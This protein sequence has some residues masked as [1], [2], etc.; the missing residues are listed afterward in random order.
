MK[1]LDNKKFDIFSQA[2]KTIAL[3]EK[4]KGEVIKE[5]KDNNSEFIRPQITQSHRASKLRTVLNYLILALVAYLL[6]QGLSYWLQK[7]T[8]D[9]AQKETKF[10]A[11]EVK[12]VDSDKKSTTDTSLDLKTNSTSSTTTTTTKT[13]AGVDKGS[14]VVRIL[15]GNGIAGDAKKYQDL[16][17]S[18]GFNVAKVGNA[19]KQDYEIG[20][21]YYLAGKKSEAEAVKSSFTDKT[22]TLE[23]ETVSLIGSGYDILVVLGSK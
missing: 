3:A 11:F 15:N 1:D 8:Q 17:V 12:S 19:T 21:I 2:P 23:E 7:K 13:T 20:I 6:A 4:E 14:F 9:T 5:E 16:L 10:S 18:A 22:F